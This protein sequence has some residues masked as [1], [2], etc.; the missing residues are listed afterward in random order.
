ALIEATI[1]SLH[2]I[3]GS[4]LMFSVS[5]ILLS[6]VSGSGNTAMSLLIEVVTIAFYLFATYLIAVYYQLAIEWVWSVEYVYFLFMGGVSVIYLR[7][8]KKTRLQAH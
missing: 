7:Y 3:D 6:A 8:A 2:V 1:P 5:S 4:L